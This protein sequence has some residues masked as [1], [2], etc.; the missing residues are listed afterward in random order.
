MDFF[1]DLYLF[2]ETVVLNP[3]FNF[4]KNVILSFICKMRTRTWSLMLFS[5]NVAPVID[6]AATGL[7]SPTSAVLDSEVTQLFDH[8]KSSSI[9]PLVKGKSRDLQKLLIYFNGTTTSVSNLYAISGIFLVVFVFYSKELLAIV[10]LLFILQ[11][12]AAL[13][14]LASTFTSSL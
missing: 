14:S 4:S 11:L 10:L 13:F 6:G 3:C 5:W 1:S 7:S 2:Q 12:P 8:Y 9:S